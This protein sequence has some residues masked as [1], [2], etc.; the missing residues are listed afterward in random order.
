M[1]TYKLNWFKL[2]TALMFG[3]LL[4]ACQKLDKPSLPDNYP[5]DPDNPGG[6]LKFY[7]A[8]ENTTVDSIKA[9]F[10]ATSTISYE[11][12]IRG[13]AM[14]GATGKY[15]SYGAANDVA[16]ATSLSV[17]LWIN[18][19]KHDGGAQGVFMLPREGDFWGNLF[20][21]IEGNNG[22][23]DSMFIKFHFAGQWAEFGGALRFPDMYGKWRH[24]VFTY[25]EATS[26]FAAY[27]DG[28]A[29]TLPASMTDRKSGGNPLGKLVWNRP[30]KFIFG[31]F[32]QH[33]GSPWNAPEPWMLN[34]TGLLDQFRIYSKA[35]SPAEVKALFDSKQ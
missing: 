9:T 29:R 28:V 19:Q 26:K 16:K 2:G 10:A 6:T 21:M 22:P 30:S 8:F 12:G 3:S 13:R 18:T 15:I 7:T 33:L 5:V 4:F 14:K 23:T 32:Q 31:G 11:N 20:L 1:M 25:D 35:L 24:L 34:Y 27:L 17:S